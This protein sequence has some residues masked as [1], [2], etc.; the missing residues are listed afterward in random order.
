MHRPIDH[1]ILATGGFHCVNA[2]LIPDPQ[3]MSVK[4]EDSTLMSLVSWLV[5]PCDADRFSTDDQDLVLKTLTEFEVERTAQTIVSF[6]CE[7]ENNVALQ[8]P[9]HLLSYAPFVTQALDLYI[10]RALEAK[11]SAI[12]A[13][14]F[15]Y[16]LGDTSYGE[17]CVDEVAAQHL[18]THLIVHYGNACL[19]PTRSLPVL[20][21]FPRHKLE[22]A[23]YICDIVR[24]NVERLVSKQNVD[25]LVILYDIE[26]HLYF[27]RDSFQIADCVTQYHDY[28]NGKQVDTAC[29]RLDHPYDV[30]VPSACF[31]KPDENFASDV[32]V[33]GP[34]LY[35][36]SDIPVSRT[37]FL[38]FTR[39]KLTEELPV[40]IRNVA[41]LLGSGTEPSAVFDVISLTTDKVEASNPNDSVG[42]DV[43]RLLR[44]RYGQLSKLKDAERIGV[45]A[46]TLGTSGNTNVID[47]CVRIIEHCQKRAYVT[48]IGKLNVAKLANF[49]DIDAFVLVACPQNTIVDNTKDYLQPI[50]TPLELEAALLRDGDIF[51]TRYTTDFFDVLREPLALHL[52]N[53]GLH[54]LEN[55]GEDVDDRQQNAV[56]NRGDWTMLV[57]GG[58]DYLGSRSWQGL[59]YDLGG[60]ENDTHVSNLPLDAEQG[61]QGIASHYDREP[62]ISQKSDHR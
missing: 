8:F 49:P 32:V 27:T 5:K 2:V 22:D 37:A 41:L 11:Q 51:S 42:N 39:N 3:T 19:S 57:N 58:S 17:C 15:V 7:E 53:D 10:G 26:L 61:Q 6:R 1:A 25:R 18:D 16:V 9:D 35:E 23:A 62:D 20:Y 59:A 34:L 48:V 43:Q 4:C 44:K 29:L 54:E 50:V 24:Q 47:R 40:H 38:W 33:A 52:S 13:N 21:V 31:V 14:Y 55:S 12:T 60:P 46:G 56:A 30:Q 28:N 36:R 45:V